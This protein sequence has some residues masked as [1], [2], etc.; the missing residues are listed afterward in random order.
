M[1]VQDA[2]KYTK[3]PRSPYIFPLMHAR[4]SSSFDWMSSYYQTCWHKCQ[5]GIFCRREE[6]PAYKEEVPM[7]SSFLSW[8]HLETDPELERT[9]VWVILPRRMPSPMFS[10]T[11]YSCT[12]VVGFKATC[13]TQFLQLQKAS[14]DPLLSLLCYFLMIKLL[15]D[16]D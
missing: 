16:S 1:E 12:H 3:S 14:C 7:F 13:H 8:L 5:Y 2:M 6:E 15:S 9:V 11:L 10:L 4:C